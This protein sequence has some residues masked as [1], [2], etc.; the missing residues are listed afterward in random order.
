MGLNTIDLN[1]INLNDNNVD[2]NDP[3]TIIHVILM[4]WCSKHKQHE[5]CQKEISRE[6]M[7]VAYHPTRWQD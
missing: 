2:E 3:E 1:N 5:A 7:P 6:L 4:A